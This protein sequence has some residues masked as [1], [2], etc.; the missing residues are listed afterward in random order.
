MSCTLESTAQVDILIRPRALKL[1][2]PCNKQTRITHYSQN[3]GLHLNLFIC[4]LCIRM[5]GMKS[6]RHSFQLDSYP[7]RFLP[8]DRIAVP[9]RVP[10]PNDPSLKN[11][12]IYNYV[13][14]NI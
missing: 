9:R 11:I 8:A 3:C 7:T 6:S 5:Y 14:K 13:R 12:K 10:E 4:Q 2:L 1:N